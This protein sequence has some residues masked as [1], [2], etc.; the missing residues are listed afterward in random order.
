MSQLTV[1]ENFPQL[2]I[3]IKLRKITIYCTDFISIWEWKEHN[4]SL[5]YQD[6]LISKQGV[7]E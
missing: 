4:I 1:T 2:I 5:W 6:I 3:V 7:P